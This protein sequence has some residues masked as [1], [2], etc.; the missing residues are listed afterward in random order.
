[1]YCSLILTTVCTNVTVPSNQIKNN[2]N[3]DFCCPRKILCASLQSYP[4]CFLFQASI[5]LLSMIRLIFW[6]DEASLCCKMSHKSN[7]FPVVSLPPHSSYRLSYTLKVRSKT[8][9]KC[10]LNISGTNILGDTG[11]FLLLRVGG[12]TP[13][14]AYY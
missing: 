5:D 4:L 2:Q 8:L 9:V 6:R 14:C 12:T 11:Y 3:A 10:R 7:C 13:G 1:M